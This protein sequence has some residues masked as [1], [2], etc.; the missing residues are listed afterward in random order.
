MQT[1]HQ[2]RIASQTRQ[3][4]ALR[5]ADTLHDDDNFYSFLATGAFDPPTE[6][7]FEVD[8]NDTETAMS[9]AFANA[10]KE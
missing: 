1:Q 6:D 9:V 3:L 4:L 8:N 7:S 10:T 2:R 5:R